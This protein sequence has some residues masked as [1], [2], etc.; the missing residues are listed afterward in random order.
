[1]KIKTTHVG[2]LP[3]SEKVTEVL[4]ALEN[5][6]R[7]KCQEVDGVFADAVLEVVRRQKEVGVDIPSD[8][9]VSKISYAT[10]IKERVD[11]FEGDSPRQPPLDLEEFPNF[12]KKIA[13]SGGTPTYKRPQCT[14]KLGNYKSECLLADIARFQKALQKHSY[15]IGFLN[16]ASPGVIALFQ[17]SCYYQSTQ[18]YMQALVGVMKEEYRLIVEA[19]LLLQIDAPDLALGRHMM[20]KNLT[21]KEFFQKLELHIDAINQAI[22]GIDPSKIRLHICWGNYEGPHHHDIELKKILP[23]VK[24]LKV[25]A[26]LVEASNPR[27]AHEWTVWKNKEIPEH[28]TIIPGVVDSTTN[29]IE[30]PELVKQKI[31]NFVN[32]LG[33]E[34]VMAGSDCG[35]STFAGFGTVDEDIVY[36]KLRSMKKGVELFYQK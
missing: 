5:Q 21:D 23:F 1:M 9:E 4:F 35:F 24:K 33:E 10:Y 29:F 15:D 18:E 20:Y 26:L 28:W 6:K 2:S 16:S 8:G 36:E 14:A 11:G 3:R 27:H 13:A 19:G 25:G 31:E 7:E 17:P 22:A 34:R 32:I 12:L 30:H